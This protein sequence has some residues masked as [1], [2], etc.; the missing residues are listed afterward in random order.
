[1]KNT[2]GRLRSPS[3]PHPSFFILPISLTNLN[4][5]FLWS[6]WLYSGGEHFYEFCVRL[7]LEYTWN[8]N[9]SPKTLSLFLKIQP[10]TKGPNKL[11]KRNRWFIFRCPNACLRSPTRKHQKFS[12]KFFGKLILGKTFFFYFYVTCKKALKADL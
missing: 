1:M 4:L 6:Y 7:C 2:D 12:I 10:N 9:F 11:T 8:K 3:D 5:R